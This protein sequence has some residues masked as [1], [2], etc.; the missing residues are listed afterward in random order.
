ML[1]N[2]QGTDSVIVVTVVCTAEVAAVEAMIE[3]TQTTVHL[4]RRGGPIVP[5]DHDQLTTGLVGGMTDLAMLGLPGKIY[6]RSFVA[7]F[8]EYLE[9]LFQCDIWGTGVGEPT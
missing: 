2:Q 5:M 6:L 7:G 8:K 4:G 9:N 1:L 3:R